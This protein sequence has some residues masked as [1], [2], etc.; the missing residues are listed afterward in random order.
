MNRNIVEPCCIDISMT[1][2]KLLRLC[3]FKGGAIGGLKYVGNRLLVHFI[4]DFQKINVPDTMDTEVQLYK[5][6]LQHLIFVY[7]IKN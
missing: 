5:S 6:C 4:Q 3:L 1:E 7:S 2:E